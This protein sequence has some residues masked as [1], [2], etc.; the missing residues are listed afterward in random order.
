MTEFCRICENRKNNLIHRTREMM[1]GTREEFDYLECGSCGTIQSIEIPNLSK[2]YPKNY[3]SFDEPENM[4]ITNGTKSRI[5]AEITKIY[6]SLSRIL[7]KKFSKIK[8]F[9]FEKQSTSSD[10]R[11][12]SKKP[13]YSR[14]F[15]FGS[16]AG[17]VF[18]LNLKRN[19]KILD[20]GSGTGRLLNVLQH[21]GFC[22]L[23]G[24]DAFIESDISYPNGV[25]IFKRTL[26]ELQPGYDLIMFHHSLEHLINPLETLLEARRLLAE[27]GVCLVRIPLVN[28]AWEKYGT[29]WAALDPPR[30]IFLFTEK[31]F[32][33]LAEKAGLAAEKIVYDSTEFQF[34]ASEQYLRDIPLNDER[35]VTKSG[36]DTGVFTAKEIASWK[37][38]AR[39]LNA[40]GK[41]D[42]ACFYLKAI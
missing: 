35:S 29:N 31:S 40:E 11:R 27:D 41:G 17:T 32:L 21:F 12:F 13:L 22:E 38:Q 36:T 10:R 1:F 19:A 7:P 25:K 14:I 6:L 3:L 8:N 15:D 37:I 4:R 23:S 33:Q 30:H 39:K 5:A 42:Q 20:F 9:G 2:Y 16:A 18:N 28:F 34:W 24:V 26:N